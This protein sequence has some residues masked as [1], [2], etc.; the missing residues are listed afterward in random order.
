LPVASTDVGDVR[1]MLP[2]IQ[3][4]HVVPIAAH[5]TAWPLAE[6]LTALLRDAEERARPGAANRE[7]ALERYGFEK[8]L[9]SYRGAAPTSTRRASRRS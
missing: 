5:E 6:W 4:A 2:E 9:T 1:A 3:A 7:R 8:M